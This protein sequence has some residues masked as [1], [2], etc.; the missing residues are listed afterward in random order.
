M[1][2]SVFAVSL[3]VCVVV[4]GL[5]YLHERRAAREREEQEVDGKKNDGTFHR[6]QSNY[7]MVYLMAFAADWLQGPYVYALYTDYGYDKATIGKLFVAGFGSSAVFGTLIGGLADKYGRKFNVI[8]YCVTYGLSCMTKHS[9]NFWVLMAGRLLGGIATSILFS[10]FEAW[11]VFEHNRRGYN[12]EGLSETFSKA[13]F[14]NAVIAIVSGQ[15]AGGFANTFGKVAPFDVSLGV[16]VLLGVLVTITWTENYGDSTQSLRA[17]FE[18][19]VEA[20]TSNAKIFMIGV[21]QSAFEAAMYLFVFLWTPVLQAA[22]DEQGRGEIPHGVIFSTFMV[23]CMAGSSLF[24]FL[25]QFMSA[26]RFMPVALL[27][28]A[29]MFLIANN[30]KNVLLLYICFILYEVIVGIYFPAIGTV[31][32]KFVPE[33]TRAGVMNLFRIPLN[34]IVVTLLW[35]NWPTTRV[36]YFC[37]ALLISASVSQSILLRTEKNNPNLPLSQGPSDLS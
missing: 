9:P 3:V 29:V 7:L 25:I 28:S 36:F 20:V 13:Q 17:G 26:E 27:S 2:N 19:A 5:Q 35:Y 31:R 1:Y 11:M 34:V 16:L 21:M 30:S 8:L 6:F 4:K 24:Y 14:G 33:E 10:A 22:S 12:P 37:A 23:A 15:V 18:H 32:A